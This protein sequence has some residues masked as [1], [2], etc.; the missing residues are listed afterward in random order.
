MPNCG[1]LGC[2]FL[3]TDLQKIWGVLFLVA[4]ASEQ[5]RGTHRH[6]RRDPGYGRQEEAAGGLSETPD[7]GHG[8]KKPQIGG[9]PTFGVPCQTR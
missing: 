6:R 5:T 1:N 7:M 8:S 9:V 3:P 2:F 4:L